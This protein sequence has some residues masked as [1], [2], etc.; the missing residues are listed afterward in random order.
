MAHKKKAP[1]TDWLATVGLD[2]ATGFAR[3]LF[4]RQFPDL[5]KHLNADDNYLLNP[6]IEKVLK[7]SKPKTKRTRKLPKEIKVSDGLYY[8]PPAPRR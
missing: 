3:E 6:F 5:A 8:T 4:A 7:G 2:L 1:I